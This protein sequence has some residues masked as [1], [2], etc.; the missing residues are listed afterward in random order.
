[1]INY[2]QFN[3]NGWPLF[4]DRCMYNFWNLVCKALQNVFDLKLRI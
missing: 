2:Q 3:K 1:M 4:K